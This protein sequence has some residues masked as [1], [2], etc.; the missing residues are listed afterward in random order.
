MSH[1][2]L[3]VEDDSDVRKFLERIL[4]DGGFAVVSAATIME[5]MQ[6]LHTTSSFDA[7]LADFHLPDGKNLVPDLKKLRPGLPV[8][9]LSGDPYSARAALPEANAVLGKPLSA[10]ALLGELRRLLKAA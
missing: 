5:A 6:Q 2:I 9:V 7:V 10:S 3:V 1:T 8:V 4:S